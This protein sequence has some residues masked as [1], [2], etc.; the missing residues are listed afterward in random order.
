VVL[1]FDLTASV[2]PVLR[3]L[4]ESSRTALAGL[5]PEDEIAVIS[6]T[7]GAHLQD[8]FTTDRQSTAAAIA[9]VANA[10]APDAAATLLQT[11]ANPSSR[12]VII[13]FTDNLSNAPSDGNIRDHGKSLGGARPHSEEEAVRALH[14][15]GTVV[16]APG[17]KGP[18]ASPVLRVV[19]RH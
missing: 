3:A 18:G 12:R 4:A 5:K 15:S 14:E 7:A 16:M 1:L 9:R 19:S 2:R 13:W 10:A 8:A 6:Y 11:A 17:E